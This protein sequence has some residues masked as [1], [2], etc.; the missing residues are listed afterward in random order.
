MENFSLLKCVGN[1]PQKGVRFYVTLEGISK[2]HARTLVALMLDV[3]EGGGE[4]FDKGI[5]EEIWRIALPRVEEL[6]GIPAMRLPK[7]TTRKEA[8]KILQNFRDRFAFI[9]QH[10]PE[11]LDDFSQRHENQ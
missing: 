9:M 6:N 5:R 3:H 10:D 11:I 4:V 7:S 1:H 8:E 2:A